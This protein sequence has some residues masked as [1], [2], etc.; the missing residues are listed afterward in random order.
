[1]YFL[2]HQGQPTLTKSDYDEATLFDSQNKFKQGNEEAKIMVISMGQLK[3]IS[4]KLSKIGSLSL[5]KD[6]QYQF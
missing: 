5:L 6:Q 4:K 1:L 2:R 3:A